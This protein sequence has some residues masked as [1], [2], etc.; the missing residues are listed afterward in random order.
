M[1]R[2][3][4]LPRQ[5]LQSVPV[6]QSA[7]RRSRTA[8]WEEKGRGKESVRTAGATEGS[9]ELPLAQGRWPVP[10]GPLRAPRAC[11]MRASRA[12]PM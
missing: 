3:H 1:G 12:H 4:A 8:S 7:E 11:E 6:F 10:V 9:V 5:R 2:P